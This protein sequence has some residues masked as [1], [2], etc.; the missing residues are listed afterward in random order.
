MYINLPPKAASDQC[1]PKFSDA[2]HDSAEVG[3]GNKK[4]N[5]DGG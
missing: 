2:L 1:A 5:Q 3:S 4:A